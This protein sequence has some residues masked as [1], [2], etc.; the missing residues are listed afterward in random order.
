LA[1]N[2]SKLYHSRVSIASGLSEY[3]YNFLDVGRSP[4]KSDCIVVLSGMNE[5]KAQ[6][7]KLW[8][9]GFA[10]QLVLSVGRTEC[11]R[12]SELG[13]EADG[14]LASLTK[15]SSADNAHYLLRVDHKE[16]ICTQ[17]KI[18]HIGTLSECKLLF[19]Y[20][21]LLPIRSLLIV[22][23][24]VRLRRVS[25]VLRRAFRKSGI[26]LTFV[27]VSEKA[28]P[29]GS[30]ATIWSEFFKYLLCKLF[31]VFIPKAKRAV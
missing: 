12:V 4:K 28:D 3:I 15:H 13:L 26:R 11:H 8:R 10:N 20:L 25:L 14:G 2:R 19:R 18:G 29:F 24:P 27:A 31:A 21:S 16:V 1:A 22:S 9:F 6:A 7:V 5:P 23:S 17:A 30:Q